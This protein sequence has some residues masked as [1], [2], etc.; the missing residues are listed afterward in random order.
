MLKLDSIN[1]V[2]QSSNY[3]KKLNLSITA[4]E[5]E[6]SAVFVWPLFDVDSCS[7]KE[8]IWSAWMSIFLDVN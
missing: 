4:Y 7:G 6:T 5:N 8:V 1:K 2:K 3:E